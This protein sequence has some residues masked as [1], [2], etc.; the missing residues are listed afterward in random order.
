[1]LLVFV[2]ESVYAAESKP[3]AI[4]AKT[5]SELKTRATQIGPKT[6]NTS[7]IQAADWATYNYDAQHLRR[8][9]IVFGYKRIHS[10]I[11]SQHSWRTATRELGGTQFAR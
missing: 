6:A 2:P 7:T 8:D 5:G 9:A 3:T 10:G 1:M 11:A 4:D